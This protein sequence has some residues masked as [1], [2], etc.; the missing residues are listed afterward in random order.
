MAHY[1][2]EKKLLCAVITDALDCI[3]KRSRG[4]EKEFAWFNSEDTTA[5]HSFLWI[6]SSLGLE[7]ECIRD[8][9]MQVI[10]NP[11]KFIGRFKDK[12]K[13]HDLL[14]TCLGQEVVEDEEG[15]PL[16]SIN[17]SFF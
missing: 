16:T 2:E 11:A 13:S 3:V 8:V 6:C 15:E 4:W 14:S 1:H 7:P 5:G 12:G 17:D 9:A 10:D